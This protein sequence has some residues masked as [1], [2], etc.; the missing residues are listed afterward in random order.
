MNPP[1]PANRDARPPDAVSP[2]QHHSASPASG[3]RATGPQARHNRLQAALP[4]PVAPGRQ[5]PAHIDVLGSL[6]HKPPHVSRQHTPAR[7]AL[8]VALLLLAG[9]TAHWVGLSHD[10]AGKQTAHAG[11][12]APAPAP[13][14][15]RQRPVPGTGVPV[16]AVVQPNAPQTTAP[17]PTQGTASPADAP[18]PPPPTPPR[19]EDV[20]T[21]RLESWRSAWAARDVETYLAH[22]S[23]HFVPADGQT[24]QG[25]ATTRRRIIST[26][27]AITL[28]VHAVTVQAVSSE[29]WQ[30]RFQQDYAA[31]A[32]V[33]KNRAKWLDWVQEDGTWRIVAERQMPDPSRTA[34]RRP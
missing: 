24:R 22:Y 2:R 21:A 14:D 29:R 34:T 8:P 27:P 31:G 13:E 1:H 4:T 16:S 17:G 9:A 11:P 18:T 25:W 12:G 26:R 20:L 3:H 32:L 28:S 19:T 15:A 6:S 30:T 10:A 33:E 23:V 5:L 7:W